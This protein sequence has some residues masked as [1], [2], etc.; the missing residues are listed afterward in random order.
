MAL[1]M[2]LDPITATDAPVKE[3]IERST[4][5]DAEPAGLSSR[6]QQETSTMTA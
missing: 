4:L 1:E 3:H 6:T 2:T 5:V